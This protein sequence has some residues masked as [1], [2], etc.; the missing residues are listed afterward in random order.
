ML[1]ELAA[2]LLLIGLSAY[3]VLGGADFGAGF[4]DLTASGAEWGSWTG[5]LPVLTGLI[6]VVTA[7]HL[8]AVFLGADARRA[9][10]DELVHA[11]RRRAL[12]SGVVA[13]APG[14]PRAGG[15]GPP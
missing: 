7:A 5:A 14:I 8:A 12:G 15:G 10:H 9:G 13:G 11:F 3:L 6:A 2:A 1:P 4:W